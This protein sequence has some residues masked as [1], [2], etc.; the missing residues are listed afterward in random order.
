MTHLSS[1]SSPKHILFQGYI[2][3]RV[4]VGTWVHL[5]CNKEGCECFSQTFLTAL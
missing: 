3:F 5:E 1:I 2:A 4:S